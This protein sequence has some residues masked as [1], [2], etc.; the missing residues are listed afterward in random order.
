MFKEGD[1]K[2]ISDRP[3]PTSTNKQDEDDEITVYY[4]FIPFPSFP[5]LISVSNQTS[6]VVITNGK[7]SE[8]RG[9]E[10][11]YKD[12]FDNINS[13]EEEESEHLSVQIEVDIDPPPHKPGDPSD[14]TLAKLGLPTHHVHYK[15]GE[16]NEILRPDDIRI[17]KYNDASTAGSDERTGGDT[18][19]GTLIRLSEEEKKQLLDPEVETGPEVPRALPIREED[20]YR[21]KVYEIDAFC[22]LDCGV[23]GECF[24][25]RNEKEDTIKKR[26][27]CPHGK[28]GKKCSMG[29]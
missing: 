20:E 18:G 1:L 19:Q 6:P 4:T 10:E 5:F 12:D 9:D 16:D 25:S 17:V 29:K 3:R 7:P 21:D 2:P 28:F 23:E 8:S 11:D 22:N 27:L 15:A 13:I 24:M 26:C 14:E